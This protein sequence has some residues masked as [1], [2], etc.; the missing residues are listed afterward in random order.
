M[1]PNTLKL[2]QDTAVRADGRRIVRA[3]QEPPNVYYVVNAD[4][5]MY[6]VEAATLDKHTA[7][8]ID[9]AVRLAAAKSDSQLWYSRTGVI[10]AHPDGDRATFSL[11]YSAPLTKLS[12]WDKA[13]GIELS[14]PEVY[15]LLRT[16]FADCLNAHGSLKDQVGKVDFKKVQEASASMSRTGVSMSRSLIAESSGASALPDPLHFH[17]PVFAT[18]LVPV[19]ARVRVAFDLDAQAEKFRF[20]VLP[21]E[22]EAACVTGEAKLVE[23]IEAAKGHHGAES[24]VYYG[25]PG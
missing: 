14:Q 9:T 2:V 7:L 10:A 22:I 16:T 18:P 15:R 25:R 20:A 12:E 4:G 5:S 19:T 23:M 1:D 3:E 11:V 24:P 21:G 13:G 8:D 6:R 17:V